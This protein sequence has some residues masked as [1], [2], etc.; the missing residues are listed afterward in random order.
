MGEA[1]GVEFPTLC[2]QYP[3][4]FPGGQGRERTTTADRSR[5]AAPVSEQ[6]GAADQKA[7]LAGTAIFEKGAKWRKCLYSEPHGAAMARKG[8]P[9]LCK[10][11]SCVPQ[12]GVRGRPAAA[13]GCKAALQCK[14][15]HL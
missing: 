4:I 3:K 5:N 2:A 14:P 12:G 1:L 7:D 8:L 10:H 9:S 13:K 11:T 15:C 6:C